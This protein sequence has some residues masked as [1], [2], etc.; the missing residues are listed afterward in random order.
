[1]GHPAKRGATYEDLL[2]VPPHQVAEIIDGELHTTPRPSLPHAGASS[3]L[4]Y[5]LSGPFRF[6]IGGPGGWIIL[7]EPELHLQANV[8]VPDLAGWRRERMPELPRGAA[9]E[10]APD[11]LCEVLSPSTEARDR[12]DKLPLYAR[13]EVDHVWLVNPDVRTLEVL[14]RQ[15]T[16]WVLVATWKGESK[17]RAAPFDAIELD[18]ALLWAL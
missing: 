11:W 16:Q 13:E 1:M 12:A 18:L 5:L 3:A 14:R 9:M 8:V 7:D 10:L 17:V 15:G 2:K 6:G 4:G